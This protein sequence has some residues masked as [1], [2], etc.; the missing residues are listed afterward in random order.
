LTTAAVR[1]KPSRTKFVVV[2][3]AAIAAPGKKAT[4]N[5]A[6][7]AAAIAIRTR[8]IKRLLPQNRHEGAIED[9]PM[10]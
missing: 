2:H 7:T 5:A 6:I 8:F 4:P 9:A 3:D 1:L 10:S